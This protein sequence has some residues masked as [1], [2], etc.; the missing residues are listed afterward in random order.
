MD[1]ARDN[2]VTM[3]H[4]LLDPVVETTRV[5]AEVA[6][7]NPEFFRTEQ[8]RNVLY[9]ALTSAKQIDAFYTSFEDGYH[10]VVTR[11]D[12]DRRRSDPQIP[13]K[14]NWHSSYIDAYAGDALR[15]RHRTFFEHWPHEIKRYSVSS[16]VDMR[17][18]L[19]Q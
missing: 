19:R 16:S 5:V 2:A 9:T 12:E 3:S 15:Q 4:N 18:T 14:A 11:I 10:R 13:S 17:K 6:G 7:T 1:S 8:S